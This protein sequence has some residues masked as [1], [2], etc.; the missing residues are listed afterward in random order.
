MT[1][2]WRSTTPRTFGQRLSM[3]NGN[4]VITT[5]SYQHTQRLGNVKATLPVGRA[6]T[7]TTRRTDNPRQQGTALP[8]CR[9]TTSSRQ[10]TLNTS[11]A[12]VGRQVLRM[13]RKACRRTDHAYLRTCTT[14]S[15]SIARHWWSPF[16]R[17]KITVE[18]LATF[19]GPQ[20]GQM[21]KIG[22]QGPCKVA[23]F[24]ISRKQT[25]TKFHQYF[26]CLRQNFW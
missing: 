21:V 25:R 8:P 19:L 16:G 13:P 17:A 12:D 22:P 3:T 2:S 7:F 6:S 20:G 5:Y 11:S 14:A 23:L 4:G 9:R 26:R 15:S 10:Q 24:V 1:T 18:N